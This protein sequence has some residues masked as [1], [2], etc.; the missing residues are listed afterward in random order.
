MPVQ[1]RAKN[2]YCYNC[3]IETHQTL[4]HN[5]AGRMLGDWAAA[6]DVVQEAF[7]SGY[8]AFGSFRGGNVRAWLLRIVAN[9]TKDAIRS[10]SG[11][12]TLSLDFSP[13]NPEDSADQP[14]IDVP[15]TA[16]SPEEY[17]VRRELGR[18]IHEGL[19]SLSEERR[20][21]VNSADVQG[22]SYEETAQI[23]GCSLGTVKSRI[24]RGRADMRD[25]LREHRELLPDKFRQD[26]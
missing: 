15:S 11:R 21:A 1:D 16:E 23:M 6:E 3:L 20:L 18:A 8:R 7:I 2:G 10:R 25:F 14:S 13:L 12:P 26:E 17:T 24:A 9:A 5:L 19:S 22:F 4:A